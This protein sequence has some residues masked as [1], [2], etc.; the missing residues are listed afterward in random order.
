MGSAELL[1]AERAAKGTVRD[2]SQLHQGGHSSPGLKMKGV[3]REWQKE[4]VLP[5]SKCCHLA[6]RWLSS[7]NKVTLC[8]NGKSQGNEN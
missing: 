2:R 6:P 7:R 3:R 8:S 5:R 1:K 4:P